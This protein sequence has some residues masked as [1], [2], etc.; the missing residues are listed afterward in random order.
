MSE[1]IFHVGVKA[2]IQ[3]D[4]GQI[5]LLEKNPKKR[6][7]FNP[8]HW[9]LPGGRLKKGN[10]LLQALKRE[11]QEEIGIRDLKIIRLL[12]VSI[13]NFRVHLKDGSDVGLILFTYLCKS[14]SNVTKLVDDEHQTLKW[15]NK[16]DAIKLLKVKFADSLI[17]QIKKI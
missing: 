17:D 6:S 8:P 11:V 2:I 14:G 4:K 5:L 16:N 3:N 9:D 7:G 12:D 1:D 13:S 10:Q 15:C